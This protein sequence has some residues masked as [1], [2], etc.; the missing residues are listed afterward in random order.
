MATQYNGKLV[1]S[2]HC[3]PQPVC[4]TL[5]LNNN[6]TTLTTDRDITA[7]CCDGYNNCHVTEA[8]VNTT[9]VIPANQGTPITCYNGIYVNGSALVSP[10]VGA[11]YGQCASITYTTTYSGQPNTLVIYSC[12]PTAVCNSLSLTNNCGTIDQTGFTGCCCNTNMCVSPGTIPSPGGS[13]SQL[14]LI[15]SLLIPFLI[16]VYQLVSQ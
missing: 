11:C 2:Y 15:A 7:C 6:C 8:A 4:K 5:E 10:T 16:S 9:N 3:I 13:T 1:K 12:D 14:S